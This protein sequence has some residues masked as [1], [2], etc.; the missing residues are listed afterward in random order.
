MRERDR[1]F[2]V[3]CTITPELLA[4][5]CWRITRNEEDDVK[6]RGRCSL[7]RDMLVG[8]VSTGARRFAFT[9]RYRATPLKER[10]MTVV[11]YGTPRAYA[12]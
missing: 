6:S 1:R 4:T 11:S 5:L 3:N 2:H 12:H 9:L 7:F 10:L 8:T